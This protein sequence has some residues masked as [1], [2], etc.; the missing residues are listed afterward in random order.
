[1][2]V[3]NP[4]QLCPAENN[5]RRHQHQEFEDLA[6]EVWKTFCNR[7][8]ATNQYLL[9][10]KAC[11]LMCNSQEVRHKYGIRDNSWY[12]RSIL[13]L[14]T[15]DGLLGGDHSPVFGIV[16]GVDVSTQ[17]IAIYL[18]VYISQLN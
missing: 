12:L 2:H 18:L 5:A 14:H 3:R 8:K 10:L 4:V 7:H 11:A 15:I 16:C 1:M 9:L 13:L 17:D 6:A